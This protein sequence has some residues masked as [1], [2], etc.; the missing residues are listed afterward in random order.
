V[1]APIPSK[2]KPKEELLREEVRFYA[3]MQ[4]KYMQW[5]FTVLVSLQTAIFFVRRDLVQ[6]YVDAGTIQKRQ[7]LPYYRY[8]VGTFFQLLCAYVLWRLT[9]RVNAQYRHYK[10]QLVKNNESGIIDKTTTGVST[11]M[12]YLYFA[13]PAYDLGVRIWIEI[14][15]HFH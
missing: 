10:E 14:T 15:L 5:G 2:G 4:Q 12:R 9:D 1:S 13:F 11:W 3:D 8:F 7:E 6:T